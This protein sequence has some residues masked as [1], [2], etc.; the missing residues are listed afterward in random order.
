MSDRALR[1]WKDGKEKENDVKMVNGFLKC[2]GFLVVYIVQLLKPITKSN[3][4]VD[5]YQM[6]R[7]TAR[8]NVTF[9]RG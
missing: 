1:W 4:P 8:R 6:P 3:E 5:S 7:P 2:H 9:V